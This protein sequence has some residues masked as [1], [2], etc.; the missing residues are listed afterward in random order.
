MPPRRPQDHPV[1]K[2]QAMLAVA[3]IALVAPLTAQAVDAHI[4]GRVNFSYARYGPSGL[5]ARLG[6]TLNLNEAMA[7]RGLQ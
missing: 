1:N 5:D 3:S 2:C 7:S 4:H 6:D